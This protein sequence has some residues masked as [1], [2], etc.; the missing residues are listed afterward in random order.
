MTDSEGNDEVDILIQKQKSF[1]EWFPTFMYFDQQHRELQFRV[2][3]I[4][5]QGYTYR[6]EIVI[7]E[8]NSDVLKNVYKCEVAIA[9]EIIDKDSLYVYT[10]IKFRIS[11]LD[12]NSYGALEFN[13][14]VDTA[15]V[16]DHFD[17]LFQVYIKNITY[18][19]NLTPMTLDRFDITNL[20]E[21]NK[22]I[23]FRAQFHEPFLLG[24]L[25]KRKDT[26]YIHLKYNLLDTEGKFKP[27][28]SH[29]NGM[30]LGNASLSRIY[31]EKCQ[32][33]K[34]EGGGVEITD[35]REQ[36]YASK[37]INI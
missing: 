23:N 28:F 5:L 34:E 4:F 36:I 7:K 16:R 10:D 11:F 21:D 8:K 32:L 14:P 6:F 9:G 24:L 15:F 30:F 25:I 3:S 35:N 19:D 13:N 26:L 37:R 33:D 12:R 1:E 29:L 22:T 20:T 2:Y 18:F 17:E 27:E 31:P